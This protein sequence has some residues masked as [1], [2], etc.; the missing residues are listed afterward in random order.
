MGC[1]HGVGGSRCRQVHKRGGVYIKFA[2]AYP[3]PS[4]GG[5][6]VLAS[7]GECKEINSSEVASRPGCS[8]LARD[9]AS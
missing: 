9:A 3:G 1:A 2:P 6:A 8:F 7:F 4:T 5:C